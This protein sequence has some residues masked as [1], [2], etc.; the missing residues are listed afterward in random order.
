MSEKNSLQEYCQKHKLEMPKYEAWSVGE[1][2]K[3]QWYA[4]VIINIAGN[5]IT[6]DTIVP[7][8]SKTAA[9]KQVAV[10]MVDHIR[11]QDKNK[12]PSLLSK[13]KDSP[14]LNP[15]SVEAPA[16][17]V[18]LESSSDEEILDDTK[19]ISR[20]KVDDFDDDGKINNIYFID[21]ENKPCFVRTDFKNDTLYIGFINSIHHSVVKYDDWYKCTKD[22]IAAEIVTSG[23][24][25]LMYL[26]E[27]GTPDLADHF[28][29]AM[30]YPLVDYV[31]KT[32]ITPH[33]RIVSGDHAGWCTRACLERIL[34]WRN[35]TNVEITNTATIN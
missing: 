1:A 17:K 18:E 35:I 33:I 20:T 21:L 10:L 14:K 28:M 7:V 29:T 34:K 19:Y 15:T 24:N 22:D 3:L 8:S 25:R 26:V 9:E 12:T 13:L 4:K 31:Q 27:G 30:L 5:N 32:H 16:K 23:K 2:H 6:M 11:N